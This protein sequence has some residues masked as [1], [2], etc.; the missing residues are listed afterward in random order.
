MGG[1]GWTNMGVAIDPWN[2]LWIG[3][4][5]NANVIRIPYDSVNH[6]WNLSDPNAITYTWHNMGVNPNYFQAGLSP[7]VQL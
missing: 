5:W 7:S 1:G 6:T 3:D 2:N 4:N